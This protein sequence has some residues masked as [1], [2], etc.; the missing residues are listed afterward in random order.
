MTDT[1]AARALEVLKH[2]R[3]RLEANPQAYRGDYF[4]DALINAVRRDMKLRPSPVGDLEDW[5]ALRRACEALAL[6]P[7]PGFHRDQQRAPTP[8]DR[9]VER[10]ARVEGPSQRLAW[11]DLAIAELQVI[12]ATADPAADTQPAPPLEDGAE[13]K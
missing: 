12:A 10:N 1:L 5:P 3:E 7:G 9:V 11:V 4:L 8:H 13:L 6:V 2:A